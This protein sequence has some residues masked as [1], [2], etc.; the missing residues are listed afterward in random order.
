MPVSVTYACLPSGENVKPVK[1]QTC[2]ASSL[3]WNHTIGV[4]KSIGDDSHSTSIWVQTVDL[5]LQTWSG[6]E[7][8]D[9]AI[10]GV[11][12]IDIFALW[13]NCNVV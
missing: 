5:V 13:V 4:I 9:P 8:L 10:N 2:E 3:D 7:I 1:C 11:C 6:S 12:E